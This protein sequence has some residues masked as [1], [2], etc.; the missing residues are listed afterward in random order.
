[1]GQDI[2]D[3]YSKLF[4]VQLG[5][6]LVCHQA[7]SELRESFGFFDQPIEHS[8]IDFTN[9]LETY[10]VYAI[11]SRIRDVLHIYKLKEPIYGNVFDMLSTTTCTLDIEGQT[12]RVCVS[13]IDQLL[14]CT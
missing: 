13:L 2:S 10:E 9:V 11:E 12:G 8:V 3:R 14:H 1:M 4:S 7:D 6:N 5:Q